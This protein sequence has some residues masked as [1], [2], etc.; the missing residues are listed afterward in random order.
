MV[1]TIRREDYEAWVEKSWK[2]CLF[3]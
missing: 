1:L 3:T 2:G